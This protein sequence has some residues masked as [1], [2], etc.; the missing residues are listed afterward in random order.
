MGLGVVFFQTSGMQTRIAKTLTQRLGTVYQ[1][2]VSIGRASIDLF[3]HLK[4]YDFLIRDH[5]KDTLFF[6]KELTTELTSIDN[7][8]NRK[9]SFES[10]E[11]L[12]PYLKEKF[13]DGES[14]SNLVQFVEKIKA[15]QR[16]SKK[17][18]T[19]L[20]ESL[21]IKE[22]IYTRFRQDSLVK[23]KADVSLKGISYKEDTFRF[24][25]QQLQG[26][27][28]FVDRVD[29]FSTDF[30]KKGDSI[31]LLGLQFESNKLK[32]IGT[33]NAYL[34][35]KEGQIN[36]ERAYFDLQFKEL[37]SH[38]AHFSSLAAAFPKTG[39]T[40][41]NLSLSGP[42]ERLKGVLQLQLGQ[43]IK[44]KTAFEGQFKN[45]ADFTFQTKAFEL[46]W[47]K[48]GLN[49]FLSADQQD[50]L[51][52]ALPE[53]G[54]IEAALEISPQRYAALFQI[55]SKGGN[56]DGNVTA[57]R[58]NQSGTWQGNMQTEW[59][60]VALFFPKSGKR[61]T[62]FNASLET[63]FK[64]EKAIPLALNWDFKVKNLQWNSRNIVA[65]SSSGN[66][67]GEEFQG[68]FLVNDPSVEVNF[69]WS[70][71]PS[72]T[73]K[74][75]GE[76]KSLDLSQWSIASKN[77]KAHLSSL[78]TADLSEDRGSL[79]LEDFVIDN[80]Q[81]RTAFSP[82]QFTYSKEN[83]DQNIVSNGNNALDFSLKGLFDINDFSTVAR[84]SFEEVVFFRP[85]QVQEKATSF[86]FSVVLKQQL[87]EALYP[88]LSTPED[89]RSLGYV[90]SQEGKSYF[91]MELPLL[92]VRNYSI[93]GLRLETSNNN[94]FFRTYLTATAL[95]TDGFSIRDLN[96]LSF[97]ADKELLVRLEG[98]YGELSQ[99]FELN[100]NHQYQD[101]RSRFLLKNA[102]IT[103]PQGAWVFNTQEEGVITYDYNQKQLAVQNL[104]ALNGN[105]QIALGGFFRNKEAFEI[106]FKANRVAIENLLPSNDKFSLAGKF[107]ASG[108]LGLNAANASNALNLEVDDLQVNQ[109]SLG[110][111][112]LA[113]ESNSKLNT[114]RLDGG[115]TD[116]E[117]QTL[118]FIGSVFLKEE[119]VNLDINF[120]L[121]Q[122]DFSFL[123]RLGKDK[124]TNVE[125]VL[126]GKLNLWGEA[127]HLRLDGTTEMSQGSFY[128]PTT[129]VVYKIQDK[130]K[131]QFSNA[132]MLMDDI[133]V[134]ED[135][136]GT[137]GLL[138][139][140]L[141]HT[142]F[143]AWRLNLDLTSERFLVYNKNEDPEELFYGKGFLDGSARLQ[144]PTKSL[145]LDVN[146]TTAEGTTL[147]IPWNEDKGL[148]DINF[149]DFL[150]KNTYN[151]NPVTAK[152]S[153]ID[154]DF[155]GFEMN[156]DLD[157]NQNAEIEIVV[158]QSSG[159][160]L[161]GRGAGNIL[162]ESNIDGKF[163][164]WGDFITTSGI[165]NFK[166]LSLI[167][168]KFSVLEGGTIV[169]EGDPVE[170][171]MNLEAVYEVPGG[172]NP[173]LLV[174]NPNF[175]KKI[176]TEV[177]IQL[178][179]N[180]LKP[181]DPV[182]EIIFPNA[183]SVVKSE[184][185]Y[186]LADQQRR[187]L[188]ALSLLSQGVF[189][190]DVSL[191]VQ[192]IA[193]NLY[194]KASDVFSTLLGSNSGKLDVGVNYLKG[195]E[196]PF[197]DT[198][199]EDRIGVTLTTQISDKILI[200]GKIGVPVGGVEETLIVG[201]VQ[202][203]FIL[204]E[205]GT[206]KAKVFNKEN[207]FRY[208]GDE[209]GYTQ[210]VG[211]SYQVDFDNFRELIQKIKKEASSP[212]KNQDEFDDSSGIEFI[213]KR[214]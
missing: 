63:S 206:L 104:F 103:S 51:P 109:K 45:R 114:F 191:S 78:F 192:G 115:L 202:I 138:N 100:F 102:R 43:K 108:T 177:K 175:N 74:V 198:R 196:T 208:L 2:D 97:P 190:S 93:Q 47:E 211:L 149:I 85:H 173:A 205:D 197:L 59:K 84:T 170:A 101:K 31:Q 194:E 113:V 60:D 207:E 152:I 176:P 146:G 193:N 141:S 200:N 119:D 116:V 189:I 145:T 122:F 199:T 182:F 164:I 180:L 123:S 58:E 188:Q 92:K 18:F 55:N 140:E 129:N 65:I 41:K 127:T 90:S 80:Q 44:V 144:G 151:A 35:L 125:G 214:N 142:N 157:V 24:S 73:S 94:P 81:K 186:R 159:S 77:A 187:Q 82:I 185:S 195:D 9:Y 136:M 23:Y 22:G 212:Q 121:N 166:N 33:A 131:V 203:D 75:K 181:D 117:R 112:R 128:L 174:D 156:F 6:G 124:I 204:N 57:G 50:Q 179:G 11:I 89:L 27:L 158:D 139:T 70:Y 88:D 155:R 154:N 29:A 32:T 169:W 95:E 150:P 87:I 53:N 172:A 135:M 71:S 91:K 16:P 37:K 161:S 26:V 137:S 67:K 61:I 134:F 48:Q 96:L 14:Q 153:D 213:T 25:L 1:T 132:S 21:N 42:L 183:S 184:I 201:D 36:F 126:D 130:S 66:K 171:Q 163:Y 15:T 105:Q 46:L 160:T 64:K 111:L 38:T 86:S 209:I 143:K 4:F 13:Y 167:D 12:G 54:K 17:A 62:Q 79:L 76:I 56:I 40:A 7:F 8:L 3:G 107:S 210:G 72:V 39:F 20:L 168:K 5:Q 118:G 19:L 49:I 133:L 30:Q 34:P 148:S 178:Q 110:D 69:N 162:I 28:P 106:D 52:V 83:S 68:D 10:V 98:V 120:D 99:P 147:T 165:Y